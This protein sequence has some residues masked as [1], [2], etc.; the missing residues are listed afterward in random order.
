MQDYPKKA[1]KY[2]V[3]A[4]VQNDSSSKNNLV[5]VVGEQLQQHFELQV[6]DSSCSFHV[7]PH[8]HWFVTYKKKSGGNVLVGND[9]PCKSIGIGFV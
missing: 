4:L 5:L 9:D 2:F 7:C 1:K 8:R 6:L 3:A